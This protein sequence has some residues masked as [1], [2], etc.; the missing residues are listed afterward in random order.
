MVRC[1]LINN[2]RCNKMRFLVLFVLNFF[3]AF[4]LQA[5][6]LA[7]EKVITIHGILG[8][9]WNMYY[10]AGPLENEKMEVLHWGYPS[11]DKT[12]MEHAGD[13]VI[14][15][16]EE[17]EKNPGKPIYFLA[18]SMGGLILRAALNHPDCPP[19]AH[20]GAAVLVATPNQGAAWGR[21]LKDFYLANYFGKDKAARELMTEED[22]EHLGQFPSTMNVMV[23]AGDYSLNYFLPG[24]SDGTVM[25]SETYLTTPHS[26]EIV[27]YTHVGILFSK[28]AATLIKDFFLGHTQM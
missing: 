23:I 27:H 9:P 19:E 2:R 21:M 17:A 28:Q 16:K 1:F 13:L 3:V 8:S 4:A 10:L 22:F 12:I 6:P 15:L 25:V 26:H 11:R 24:P 7:N 18:H 20:M 14:T 5:G